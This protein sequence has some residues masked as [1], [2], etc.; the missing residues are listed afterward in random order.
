MN[1]APHAALEW[2][3]RELQAWQ[4]ARLAATYSDLRL[5]P[6]YQRALDFFLSD[7]YGPADFRLR[8][9]QLARAWRSLQRALPGYLGEALDRAVELQALTAEL[10]LAMAQALP[11]GPITA[12][13]YG[14]AYRAVDQR[15]A[16]QHQIELIVGIGR[17]LDRAA[18]RRWTG[19]ALR[20]AHLPAHAAGFGALQDLLE[21]GFSAFQ[22]MRGAEGLL[23]LIAEREQDVMRALL[24]ACDLQ[25]LA[26]NHWRST[27]ARAAA[28]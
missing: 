15:N 24:S 21:R 5:E 13:L 10:D 11:P 4:A 16:R 20:A 9:R 7:L 14:A 6:R 3:L 19:L 22:A 18:R 12:N 28:P 1:E 23:S 27:E 2:R 8:D 26:N 25:A 17:D